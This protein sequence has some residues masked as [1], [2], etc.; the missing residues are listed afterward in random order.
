MIL[1]NQKIRK[2]RNIKKYNQ[3]Q[4]IRKLGTISLTLLPF[5]ATRD[6]RHL[7]P[8]RASIFGYLLHLV[9]QRSRRESCQP[10]GRI[11]VSSLVKKV[12]RRVWRS[13][14][15]RNPYGCERVVIMQALYAPVPPPS[16]PFSSFPPIY[17]GPLHPSN[18]SRFTS[19]QPQSCKDM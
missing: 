10:L 1:E 12:G 2:I 17:T 11:P 19:I 18:L 13:F 16:V 7:H 4:K 15:M 9:T 14:Y 8:P 3:N 5:Q 6:A